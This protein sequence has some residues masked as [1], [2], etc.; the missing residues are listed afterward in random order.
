MNSERKI[1]WAQVCFLLLAIWALLPFGSRIA[2]FLTEKGAIK[3]TLLLL[4]VT[5]VVIVVFRATDILSRVG[6]GFL[7]SL[8]VATSAYLWF[9]FFHQT[10]AVGVSS[11]RIRCS[12]NSA[13]QGDIPRQVAPTP[14][15]LSLLLWLLRWG[16]SMR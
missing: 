8:L 5:V 2:V 9:V 6:V 1:R 12:C 7:S 15:P 13:F 14:P 11:T 4:L 3:W 10:P 16:G